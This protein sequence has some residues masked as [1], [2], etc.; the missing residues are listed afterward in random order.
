MVVV[1]GLGGKEAPKMAKMACD[2]R[3]SPGQQLPA[4]PLPV[5]VHGA[6]TE[7]PRGVLSISKWPLVKLCSQHFCMV[8]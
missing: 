7:G 5:T 4:H 8:C 3:P 1:P 2:C 6:P